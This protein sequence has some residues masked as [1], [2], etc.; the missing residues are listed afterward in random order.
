MYKYVYI[1]SC[2][3]MRIWIY[4]CSYMDS[5]GDIMRFAN[6]SCQ[7]SLFSLMIHMW[8]YLY[9]YIYRN[10]KIYVYIYIHI[11]SHICIQSYSYESD[12]LY[13]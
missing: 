7:L 12:C 3:F 13:I 8:I 2:K 9:I 1:Y 6:Y 11:C 4:I 5:C 10:I